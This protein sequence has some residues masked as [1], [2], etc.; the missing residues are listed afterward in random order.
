MKGRVILLSRG[1]AAL[2][3]N[4][5][6]ED[7]LL[8]TG[9]VSVG[10]VYRAEIERVLPKGAGAFVTLG[11]DRPRGFLRGTVPEGAFLAQ[12]TGIP[13]P[14]KAI[15]VSERV[16]YKGRFLILTPGAPGV[17]LSRAIQKD[18]RA[19]ALKAEAEATLPPLVGADDGFIVRTGAA[20]AEDG[21]LAAEAAALIAA[22]ERAETGGALSRHPTDVALAEW[23]DAATQVV[24]ED[25]AFDRF[26]V[27]DAI[28][29]LK[30]PRTDLPSGGWLS[31]EPTA[32]LVAADVNTGGDFSPAAAL[33]ANLE[34]ARELPRQ[35]RLR[36]LG[37]QIV[38]DFAPVAK[39]ER[40]RIEDAL[41]TAFQRDPVET[42]LAG[43]TTLGL[44]ELSRKR[45]RRP[46]DPF[47]AI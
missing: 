15:P 35:L 1:H 42:S 47:T 27:W 14:G 4:G 7:L 37:G 21:A 12:V 36:G 23:Q 46:L 18:P 6:L 25:D 5:R 32:A 22:R 44:F 3:V 30:S 9:D 33:K 39:K 28:E 2:V 38:M 20:R 40:R 13:E 16:L 11:K 45:E 8:E 41:K 19:E 10:D 34:A 43:W 24:D 29:A 17:N 31:V 26:G